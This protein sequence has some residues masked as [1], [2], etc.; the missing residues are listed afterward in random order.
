MEVELINQQ[1]TGKGIYGG[2]DRM[3][4]VNR[5]HKIRGQKCATA[6]LNGLDLYIERQRLS[7]WIFKNPG[8]YYLEEI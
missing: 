1:K 6:N 7:V 2:K 5:K 8:L 4:M 3:R